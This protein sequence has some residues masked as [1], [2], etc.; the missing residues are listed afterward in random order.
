MCQLKAKDFTQHLWFNLKM[1]AITRHANPKLVINGTPGLTWLDGVLDADHGG[2]VSAA[3]ALQHLV[4]GQVRTSV[5]YS[6]ARLHVI[7]VAAVQLEEL[8]EEEAQVDVGAPCVNPRVQLLQ[9]RRGEG[10][11]SALKIT[12]QSAKRPSQAK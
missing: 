9:A 5:L 6:D 10:V 12:T 11:N 8:D 1:L 7:E 4:L 3:H 2:P